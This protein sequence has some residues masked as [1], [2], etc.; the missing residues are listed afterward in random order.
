MNSSNFNLTYEDRIIEQFNNEIAELEER[1]SKLSFDAE[2]DGIIVLKYIKC[3]KPGC[4]C[5]LD[6]SKRILHGP[7]PHF[8]YRKDG[9]LHQKY[10][11]RK[12]V[13][14]YKE[15][16]DANNEYKRIS[17]LLKKKKREKKEYLKTIKTSN[18][19]EKEGGV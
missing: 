3:G 19:E 12:N 6:I 13:R 16:V 8:Q 14:E 15:K 1:L 11:N 10:L 2:Y 17:R 4:R 5:S 7:Y 9:V 18:N